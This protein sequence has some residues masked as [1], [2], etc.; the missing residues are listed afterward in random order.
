[1]EGSLVLFLFLLFIL[2]FVLASGALI[3]LLSTCL[4]KKDFLSNEKAKRELF[5]TAHK[6][7]VKVFGMLFLGTLATLT[8]SVCLQ[9]QG[10]GIDSYQ[11]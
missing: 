8:H 9:V 3:D 4:Q 5:Q 7:I 1:M 10:F 11:G 2:L 6:M